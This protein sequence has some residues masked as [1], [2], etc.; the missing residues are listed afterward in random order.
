MIKV[1]VVLSFS[2]SKGSLPIVAVRQTL[3]DYHIFETC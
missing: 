1:F 3:K 2:I